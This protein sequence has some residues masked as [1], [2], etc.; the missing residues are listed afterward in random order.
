MTPNV[1]ALVSRY[2]GRRVIGA[3]AL[4]G[5]CVG[6]V[7]LVH[8]ADGARVVAKVGPGLEPEGWMLRHLAAISRLPLPTIVHADDDILLLEYVEA[9]KSL[10]SLSAQEHA[11]ELLADLHGIPW[12]SFGL[13]RDTLIGSL[14]QPNPPRSSWVEF[15]RDQRLLYMAGVAHRAGQLPDADLARIEV[16]AGRLGRW[17]DEPAQP[18]LI[19]GDAWG[20]NILCRNGRV[21][22]FLDPAIYYADPEIELA[23]GTLFATFG[24]R[25]FRRYHEIRP[26]QPGFHEVR[27]YLYTLYPLLVHVRLFGSSYLP[28]VQRTLDRFLG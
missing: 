3:K 12:H 27:R 21:V 9:G 16:L 24:Q 20:G 18:A 26:E 28:A 11:A 14:P 2:T 5:G 7:L 22:A 15:F 13:E 25:F 1:A 6:E 4:A 10:N 8:L 17:I 23:F 19:H